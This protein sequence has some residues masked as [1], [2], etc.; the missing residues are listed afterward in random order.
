MF[1]KQ[2]KSALSTTLIGSLSD[3]AGTGASTIAMGSGNFKVL[4]G[5]SKIINTSNIIYRGSNAISKIE[6]LPFSNQ[7]KKIAG[8]RMQIVGWKFTDNGYVI[9]TQ[10][11][12][13]NYEIYLQEA[14][15]SGEIKFK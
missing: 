13:K 14:A 12:K 15:I 6:E 8:K 5:A 4:K 1:I 7:A 9:L 2:K 3:I 11:D 10:F